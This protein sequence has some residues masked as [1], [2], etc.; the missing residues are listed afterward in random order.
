MAAALVVARGRS[1]VLR[2]SSPEIVGCSDEAGEADPL[3]PLQ[4]GATKDPH[5][6]G[7]IVGT[8]VG[9][10]DPSRVIPGSLQEPTKVLKRV[11]SG[12]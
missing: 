9:L 8:G 10:L 12:L 7:Q 2:C 11:P 3:S 6:L 4:P 1:R 5:R